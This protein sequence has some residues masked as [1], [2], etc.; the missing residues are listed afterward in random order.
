L[1]LATPSKFRLAPL[2]VLLAAGLFTSVGVAPAN[3]DAAACPADPPAEVTSVTRNLVPIAIP[4]LKAV[5]IA[6]VAGVT[7]V[8][9]GLPAGFTATPMKVNGSRRYGFLVTA[10]IAGAFTAHVTWTQTYT[11]DVGNTQSCAG[12]AD[13]PFTATH[14]TA[15]KIKPPPKEKFPAISGPIPT[16][17][18]NLIWTYGCTANSDPS[19]LAITVRYQITTHG[20]LNKHAK[21]FGSTVYDACDALQAISVEQKL[22]HGF[23]LTAG[24]GGSVGPGGSFYV[25]LSKSITH[26]YIKLHHKLACLHVGILVKQGKRTLV[27]KKYD[28]LGVDGWLIGGKTV[29]ALCTK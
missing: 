7:N 28:S 8:Q 3:A 12:A 6:G 19:P 21:S 16:Q 23:A 15:L 18:S 14:G 29:G 24:G 11:D 20:R 22:G 2:A 9:L 10:P 4:T 5:S 17:Y 1:A 27:N 13:L 26:G 25:K